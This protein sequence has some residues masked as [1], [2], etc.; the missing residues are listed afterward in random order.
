[1]EPV[2]GIEIESASGDLVGERP[3]NLSEKVRAPVAF[4]G[5]ILACCW[6]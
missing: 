2:Y 1:M 3:P 5:E 6:G 4:D